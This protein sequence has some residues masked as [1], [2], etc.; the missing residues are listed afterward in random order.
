[1]A[2]VEIPAVA[3]TPLRASL[4]GPSADWTVAAVHRAAAY[5]RSADGTVLALCTPEA[6][7]LPCTV[8]VAAMEGVPLRLCVGEAAVVGEH[9]VEVP[10]ALVRVTRWFD[11]VPTLAEP[12]AAAVER[13]GEA[14]RA[15]A[16]AVS[17]GPASPALRAGCDEL[18]RSLSD[19]DGVAAVAA[20]GGL[21]G[22]GPG[23]TPSGDDVLA[24][25]LVTL[26]LLAR[27]HDGAR[28]AWERAGAALARWVV[29]RA[30]SRTT[31]VSAALLRHAARGEPSAEVADVLRGVC[32]R[33]SL[34]GAVGRL[35]AVGH[36][37]GADLAAG[38]GVGLSAAAAAAPDLVGTA[39]NREGASW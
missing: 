29:A 16:A 4:T 5:L 32:G 17:R 21:L 15:A 33:G 12:T 38:I 26:R 39:V 14:L 9:R 36:T 3:G 20:A 28:L 11:P 35:L 13:A 23:S 18:H 37:S 25:A 30:P 24:G 6:T 31:I 8:G 19:G 27:R 2:S 1:M 22:L 7:R 10:G 34:D